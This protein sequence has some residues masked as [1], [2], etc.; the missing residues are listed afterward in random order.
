MSWLPW[1]LEKRVQSLE[2]VVSSLADQI[3]S[4][5]PA[6]EDMSKLH[7]RLANLV[8]DLNQSTDTVIANATESETMFQDVVTGLE[9]VI[10]K[11]KKKI[12]DDASEGGSTGGGSGAR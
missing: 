4:I 8:S 6:G 12:A 3:G 7:D 1:E 11:L 10:E 9:A 5:N 2:I